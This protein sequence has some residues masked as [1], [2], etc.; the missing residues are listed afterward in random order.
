M[1]VAMVLLLLAAGAAQ[2]EDCEKP[3]IE[4]KTVKGLGAF[5]DC[6]N[7]RLAG[8]EAEKAALQGRVEDLEK[9]ISGL[10]GE[11][12]DINGRVTRS[13]GGAL[14][15]AG[16]ALDARSRQAAMERRL[17]QKAV[18]QL[19]T[20]GCSVTLSLTAVGLREGDPTPIFSA[21]PC[22]FTYSAKSG[23]WTRSEA[24]GGPSVSGVDGDGSLSDAPGGAVILAAGAACILADSGPARSVDA[25]GQALAR[26][27]EKGLVLIAD[28]SLW[29]GTEQRFRCDLRIAK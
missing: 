22:A 29:T 17:D 11:M 16:F 4:N 20:D 1:R 8:L 7:A 13:G 25:E 3:T 28:P 9:L 19:C 6:A 21:G 5:V 2:A 15:R 24:C 12:T 23:A 26:D 10:P 14:V 18:E 27:R